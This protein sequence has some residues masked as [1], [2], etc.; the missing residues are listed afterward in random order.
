MAGVTRKGKFNEKKDDKLGGQPENSK[1]HLAKRLGWHGLVGLLN[2]E[3]QGRKE[4]IHG[5]GNK[6]KPDKPPKCRKKSWQAGQKREGRA[7]TGEQSV[8]RKPTWGTIR[9]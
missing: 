7:A 4:T 3:S 9:E 1:R 6:V 8:H 2:S 5:G